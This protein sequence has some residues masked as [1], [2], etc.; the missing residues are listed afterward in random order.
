M[1]VSEALEKA[2]SALPD[3]V[4]QRDEA[5]VQLARVYAAALDTTK[6]RNVLIRLG[7]EYQSCLETLHL[8]PRA[9]QAVKGGK[10]DDSS[11]PLKRVRDELAERRNSG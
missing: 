3:G 4:D 10:S 1:T 7:A 9:R 6:D 2:L 5:I 11:S 8:T